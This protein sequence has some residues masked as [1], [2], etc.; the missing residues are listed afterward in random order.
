MDSRSATHGST[1]SDTQP[2]AKSERLEPNCPDCQRSRLYRS[3]PSHRGSR[4]CGYRRSLAAGGHVAH[5]TCHE[6]FR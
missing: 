6:C 2:S 5:C 4:R 1:G 3:Y